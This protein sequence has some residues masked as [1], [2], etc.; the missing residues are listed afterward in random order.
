MVYDI[1]V[2]LDIFPLLK[3]RLNNFYKFQKVIWSAKIK[4]SCHDFHNPLTLKKKNVTIINLECMKEVLNSGLN[5]LGK[6]KF[7]MLW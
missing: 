3:A 5:H 4:L 7:P 2:I 6:I 1:H